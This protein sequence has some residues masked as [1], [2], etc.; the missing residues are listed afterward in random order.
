[1]NN[2]SKELQTQTAI[3]IVI[4]DA[5]EKGHTNTNELI[6]Y[7]KSKAFENAVNNYISLMNK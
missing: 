6:Q 2:I 3:K 1:M 5:I 4:M 7:M